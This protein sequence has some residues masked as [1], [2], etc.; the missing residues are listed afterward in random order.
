MRSQTLF[1]EHCT[2]VA[3]KIPKVQE[4]SPEQ[5]EKFKQEVA[6]NRYQL[7]RRCRPG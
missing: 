5:L 2:Q 4:L 1:S 6:I 7:S 3:V